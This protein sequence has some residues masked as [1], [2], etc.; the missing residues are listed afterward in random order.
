MLRGGK[1]SGTTDRAPF[2]DMRRTNT[3][4]PGVREEMTGM[5]ISCL[6]GVESERLYCSDRPAV[7][8][9]SNDWRVRHSR[10]ES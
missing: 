5:L 10:G 1:K 8:V 2:I 9:S 3:T 7:S 4:S 6:G